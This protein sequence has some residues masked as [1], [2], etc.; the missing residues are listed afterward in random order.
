MATEHTTAAAPIL[1]ALDEHEAWRASCLNL[2]AAENA[3][4]PLARSL[5]SSDMAQ[6]YGDY[7]GRDLRA[8]KYLGTDRI[9][10]LEEE[11][12][13]L[14][15]QV[16]QA[17]FVE[18]RPLSGHIAGNS[19]MMALCQPGDLVFE[20]GP[21]D[22]GHRLATKFASAPLIDLDVEFLPFDYKSFNI[23]VERTL[24]QVRRR[25]PRLVLVGAS[26]FL[27]PVP[28][29]ELANG[30]SEYPETLLVYDAS[31]VLGL[32]AGG[33][34]Q[35]PLSDGARLVLAG[36]QKSFP[37]PQG[38]IIYTDEAPLID[39]V[40]TA[41]YPAMLSNH[42]L[43]R[44]PSLGIALLEMKIWGAE[45]AD[46]VVQNAQKLANRLVEQQVP[47]V[48]DLDRGVYTES[49]TVL[50]NT[51][52]IGAAPALGKQLEEV[53]VVVTSIRLPAPLGGAGLRIGT[54][55]ITRRGATEQ[56]V[57]AIARTIADVL[58]GRRPRD[59][60]RG[61]VRDLASDLSQY[62]FALTN[63]KLREL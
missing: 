59:V 38:G 42:H 13:A 32:I 5:L 16:F 3:M 8:R 28:L 1:G 43:A 14:A 36:T 11:V 2:V 20:M 55:E 47:V 10:A 37:G 33:L 60:V 23:D 40:S 34:F 22:G 26:N 6:R 41:V 4:S 18:L 30:L 56:H 46:R 15:R 29:A 63:S 49:H 45:Y 12:G 51:R 7:T 17:D 19:V 53:G 35:A 21:D 25:R 62:E 57:T 24:D 44:L 58:L 50:I 54:N 61:E 39:S 9:V 31:H 52:D 48:G 27:F